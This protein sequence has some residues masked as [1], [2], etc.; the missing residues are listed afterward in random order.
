MILV[1]KMELKQ[2]EKRKVCRVSFSPL[3]YILKEVTCNELQKKRKGRNPVWR[4]FKV[5]PHKV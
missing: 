5:L 4:D 2:S 3:I 1:T